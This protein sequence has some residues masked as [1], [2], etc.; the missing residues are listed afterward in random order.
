MEISPMN[1]KNYTKSTFYF[2]TLLLAGLYNILWGTWTV[3]FPQHAFELLGMELP[4]YIELWQCVGMIVAVYGL[5]YISVAS[6][7]IK[8]W[9]VILVGFLGK[10]FGPIG[11]VMAFVNGTFPL[12]FG[13]HIIFNDLIWLVP[14]FLMLKDILAQNEEERA[15]KK[16]HFEGRNLIVALR[17]QGC[18]FCRENLSELSKINY[19]ISNTDTN[20]HILHMGDDEEIEPLISKY[21]IGNY[22]LISDPEGEYYTGLGL[23]R[24]TTSKAFGLQEFIKGF[25]GFFKFGLGPLRGDGLQL[26][27]I[28][29]L[30]NNKILKSYKS[31]RA[32]DV[33]PF[34]RIME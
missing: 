4:R 8:Y 32:S 16:L 9:P 2:Y 27:G 13:V 10:L 11:F 17:H 3:L 29:L 5:G 28:F 14:F 26:G 33:Y 6:D 23:A 19:V 25:I 22:N 12:G 20:L 34:K 7:P 18:T 30:E 21:Y 31:T 1:K 24:A 15:H